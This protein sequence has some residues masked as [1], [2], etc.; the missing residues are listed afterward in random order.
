MTKLPRDVSASECIRALEKAGFQQ[1]RQKGSHVI[2]IRDTP[3]A[4]TVVPV[5]KKK[6]RVGTLRDIIQQA[7]MTVE[8]FTRLL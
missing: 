7:G 2:L 1:R 6:L 3:F 8:E 4:M 5:N